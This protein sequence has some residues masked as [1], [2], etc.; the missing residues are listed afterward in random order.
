[1]IHHYAK[2]RGYGNLSNKKIISRHNLPRA[3]LRKFIFNIDP[4][5]SRDIFQEETLALK[6]L[7]C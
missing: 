2:Q 3:F 4:S 5:S 7:N 6:N 1:M